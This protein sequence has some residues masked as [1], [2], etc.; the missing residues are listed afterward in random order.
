MA[1]RKPYRRQIPDGYMGPSGPV[2][3]LA[4]ADGWAMVR[5]SHCM[6]FIVPVNDWNAW[7]ELA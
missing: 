1:K 4:A 5:R 3:F 6:P 7:D 2:T